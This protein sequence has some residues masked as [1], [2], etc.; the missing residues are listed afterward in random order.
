MGE[1]LQPPQGVGIPVGGFKDN[2]SFQ[3]LHQAALT[4]NAE[5]FGKIA[6]DMGDGMHGIFLKLGHKTAS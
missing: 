6:A 5:F 1:I 2:I 3:L 4:G